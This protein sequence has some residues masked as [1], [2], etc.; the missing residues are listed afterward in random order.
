[1][2][3]WTNGICPF[4]Y[5]YQSEVNDWLIPYFSDYL[6]KQ[7]SNFGSTIRKVFQQSLE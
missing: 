3:P 5:P 1:M 7:W 4:F 2:N 6:K